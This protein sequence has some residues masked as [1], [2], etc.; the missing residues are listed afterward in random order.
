MTEIPEVSGVAIPDTLI[1]TDVRTSLHS[2]FSADL[3]LSL[4]NCTTSGAFSHFSKYINIRITKK[5]FFKPARPLSCV[6]LYNKPTDN[7]QRAD[8]GQLGWMSKKASGFCISKLRN[9]NVLKAL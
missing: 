4:S 6:S 7:G 9:M 2:L 1:T 3:C 5:K 8:R